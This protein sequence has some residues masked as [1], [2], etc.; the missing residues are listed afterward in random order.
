MYIRYF[1]NFML[2]F[3]KIKNST[4]KT[5]KFKEPQNTDDVFRKLVYGEN[6]NQIIFTGP[7]IKLIGRHSDSNF[8]DFELIDHP[9]R[10]KFISFMSKISKVVAWILHN[11]SKTLFGETYE[12]ENIQSQLMN[13]KP[14][15][16]SDDANNKH[17]IK[18][19][20]YEHGGG[21]SYK[22]MLTYIIDED[23]VA[24]T[25]GN[26]LKTFLPKYKNTSFI[27]KYVVDKIRI[28]SNIV[29]YIHPIQLTIINQKSKI[30]QPQPNIEN[31]VAPQICFSDDEEDG[32]DD[33]DSDY[34]DY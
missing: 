26:T 28:G 1:N 9:D 19:F 29:F 14:I 23:N 6:K 21:G 27:P 31:K 33:E 32:E 3:K 22:Q 2:D 16:Y 5:I 13:E 12:Q 18:L 7:P 34:A 4:I 30:K 25:T 20:M 24:I 11:Q 15:I 17:N 10:K 8:H